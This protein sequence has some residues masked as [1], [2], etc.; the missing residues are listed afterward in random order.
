[1]TATQQNT[2]DFS[3][4]G[5]LNEAETAVWE[6]LRHHRG[7]EDAI[8]RADIVAATRIIAR[9][10]RQAIKN[11]IE[12]HHY[13]IGSLQIPP[14]GYF[15]IETEEE[16]D[17]IAASLYGRAM[18][19]LVRMK[20]IKDVTAL[21]VSK[22]IE[23]DLISYKPPPKKTGKVRAKEKPAPPAQPTQ[24]TQPA[25]QGPAQG[26]MFANTSNVTILH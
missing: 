21:S 26:D 9:T 10:V 1:M 7:K 17:E 6:V 8:K 5:H 11:L 13:P 25:P 16:A 3:A 2:L 12:H 18:S 22:Q 24:P 19:L 4:A 14:Y 15:V 23:A 20:H